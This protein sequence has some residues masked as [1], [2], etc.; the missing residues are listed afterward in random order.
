M[1]EPIRLHSVASIGPYSAALSTREAALR[2][3]VSETTL[4]RALREA[5]EL[6][7]PGATE[8]RGICHG[9]G[10]TA[11]RMMRGRSTAWRFVIRDDRPARPIQF[12]YR[13]STGKPG[14][15]DRLFARL[16]RRRL[17]PHAPGETGPRRTRWRRWL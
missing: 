17:V 14:V 4:R 11:F 15:F 10:F 12:P 6:A 5:R 8:V 16:Q 1:A 3:G 7:A 9:Y 2:V 13:S